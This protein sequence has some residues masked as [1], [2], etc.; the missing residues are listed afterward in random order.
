[1]AP[2]SATAS[3]ASAFGMPLAISVVPSIGSTATSQCGAVAVADLLAVVEHRRL[4]LLALADDHHPAHGHGADRACAWRPRP[5]RRRRSCRPADPAAGGH[6][7]GLG[8]PDQFQGQVA[9]RCLPRRRGSVGSAWGWTCCLRGRA[10]RPVI[11]SV[12]GSTPGTREH[13]VPHPA[14]LFRGLGA[15]LDRRQC[16]LHPFARPVE[17]AFAHLWRSHLARSPSSATATRSS[18]S[19]PA[20]SV[21]APPR[22]AASRAAR[23]RVVIGAPCLLS[24]SR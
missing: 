21:A 3:T 13:G 16:G 9:V 20:S 12:A 24:P 6:R 23:S 18:D 5:R 19:P 8:H 2:R 1:M 15:V 7:G 17:V 10:A 4:V 14:A 22:P 11:L